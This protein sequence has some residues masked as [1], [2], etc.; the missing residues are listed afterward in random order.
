MNKKL[1]LFFIAGLTIS[2]CKNNIN[3]INGK[4]LNSI[5]GEYILLDELKSDRL[6]TVDSVKVADDG[7]FSFTRKIDFPSF[8]LLKTDN[9]SFLTM[10][11]NTGEKVEIT[12]YRDSLN[13]PVSLSGSE[14]T[15]LLT[16]YNIKL[17]E[18]IDRLSSLHDIYMQNLDKPELPLVMER[19]DSLAQGYL[20]EINQYT[21][22]YIDE[23]IASLVSLV[24]LY[25]QVA[26]GEYVLHPQNDLDYYIK[27]DSAM[28]L[29]YPDYAP[30][31]SLHT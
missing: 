16:A 18:I 5:K 20:N 26:P 17:R 3:E 11:L 23:N 12:A 19:L 29:L 30:V 9:S 14:G 24:A 4:L 15:E 28:W 31:K 27:V 25:Q 8:Y 21:R 13:F 6:L 1:L 10:L 22:N 7:T 2:G